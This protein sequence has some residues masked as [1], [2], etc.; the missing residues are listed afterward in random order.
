MR[1]NQ[2]EVLVASFSIDPVINAVAFKQSSGRTLY[3]S[4]SLSFFSNIKLV[5]DD[6]DTATAFVDSLMVG[7]DALLMELEDGDI[8]PYGDEL[9]VAAP[10]ILFYLERAPVVEVQAYNKIEVTLNT[11]LHKENITYPAAFNSVI[12]DELPYEWIFNET[13]YNVLNNNV[14]LGG[15]NYHSNNSTTGRGIRV[16]FELRTTEY[17]ELRKFM[18]NQKYTPFAY[19]TFVGGF[20][21]GTMMR[22]GKYKMAYSNQLYSVSLVL[23]EQ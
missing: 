19:N 4:R 18:L 2:T 16:N 21:P 17:L 22:I 6:A 8:N 10:G 11:M 23:E 5:F 1:I 3:R 13:V 9:Q 12:L 7:P 20:A 15:V 14:T